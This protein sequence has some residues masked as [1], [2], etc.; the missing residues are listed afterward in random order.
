MP[1]CAQYPGVLTKMVPKEPSFSVP[2]AKGPRSAACNFVL[3]PAAAGGGGRKRQQKHAQAGE[4]CYKVVRGK[5]KKLTGL[6]CAKHP[7]GY[8]KRL[9]LRSNLHS[10][11][12]TE[13]L[14]A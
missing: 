6:V 3:A 13:L 7:R 1:R 9:F 11:T 14:E 5:R 4:R 12:Q 2:G 8:K 10:K